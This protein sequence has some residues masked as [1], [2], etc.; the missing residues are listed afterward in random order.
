MKIKWFFVPLA[1]ILAA[2]NLRS[3]SVKTVEVAAQTKPCSGGIGGY[4]DPHPSEPPESIQNCIQVRDSSVSNTFYHGSI[5]GFT[6]E[7]GF[8]YKLRVYKYSSNG[9]M[10]DFGYMEFISILEKTPAP[11][12]A[13]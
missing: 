8:Q 10:D 7:A 2:C 11:Q 13:L 9:M 3:V 12:G 4:T 5:K 1:L 6:H